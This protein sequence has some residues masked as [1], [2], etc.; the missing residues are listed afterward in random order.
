[1][2]QLHEAQ[3][4]LDA[5]ERGFGLHFHH[6]GLAVERPEMARPFLEGLG[7]LM[8]EPI[9]D[10]EQNVNLHWCRHDSMPDIEVICPGESGATPVDRLMSQHPRGIVYHVC[11]TTKD[12]SA[13]LA[14]MKR[15]G[16]HVLCTSKP[17]PAT[18]FA[19]E[20]VSFYMVDGIGL[21]EIVESAT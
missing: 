14:A 11:Y 1:M 21:I 8:G 4:R 5:D 18:L 16:L 6:I 13:S 20:R 2:T 19:G 3:T 17:K 15:S 10:A 12:L 7:Y 9:F